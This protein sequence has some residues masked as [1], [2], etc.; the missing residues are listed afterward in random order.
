M[1]GSTLRLITMK[2]TDEPVYEMLCI[3][4]AKAKARIFIEHGAVVLSRKKLREMSTS[5]VA[6]NDMG[7][8]RGR[9]FR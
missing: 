1:D 6:T 8:R 2:L 5:G 4:A 3:I 9:P 7:A